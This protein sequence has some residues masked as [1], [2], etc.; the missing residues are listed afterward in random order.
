[1]AQV[2]LTVAGRSHQVACRDGE[3]AAVR[4]L[5]GILE[6][7]AA[8]ATR[9]SGGSAERTLLYLALML[10]EQVAEHERNPA[11]GLPPALLDRLADRLEA[12][13]TT[14]EDLPANA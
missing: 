5:G 9:A 8:V 7:H 3:E 1:M 13:A 14:L 6:R 10:A 11:A 12:L 2:V 4:A